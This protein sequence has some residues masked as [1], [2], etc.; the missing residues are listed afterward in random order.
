MKYFR[1]DLYQVDQA[2]S[3][4]LFVSILYNIRKRDSLIGLKV[5]LINIGM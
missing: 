5:Q 1:D 2:Y 4:H 3:C